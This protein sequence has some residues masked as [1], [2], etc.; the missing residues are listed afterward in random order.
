VGKDKRWNRHI[1]PVGHRWLADI[2]VESQ[3]AL[4]QL[5]AVEAFKRV[6]ALHPGANR[7]ALYALEAAMWDLPWNELPPERRAEL[8][9]V[10]GWGPVKPR[11]RSKP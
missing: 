3:D 9:G 1:G 10:M 5:G 8:D 11:R 4:E 7:I 2:G 6:K